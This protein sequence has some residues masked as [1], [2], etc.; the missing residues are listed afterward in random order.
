V[1]SWRY[2]SNVS[3]ADTLAVP[4][5]GNLSI[6]ATS[7]YAGSGAPA[8]YPTQFPWILRLEPGTSNEELVSVS[9]GAGTVAT[10]WVVVRA[11]DGTTAKAH[12]AG[13]AIAHG[14]SAFD[15]TT[16]ANHYALGSGS[17]VHGLPNAAWL[18]SAFTTISEQVTT[19]AQ[20]TVSFSG[21]PGTSAH[22]LLI[23][24]GRLVETSVQS[25]DVTLQFNGDAGAHYSY[26]T[27]LLNNAGGTMTG[28]VS[29]TGFAGTNAP[30]FR[31]LASSGGAAVNAGGGFALIP[32]YTGTAYNKVFYSLS[33]GGNGT[34]SFVD[35][36]TRLGIWNPAAQAAI[37]AITL[38]APTGGF[39]AGCQFSLYGFG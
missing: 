24:T 35:M 4:G 3:V 11:A 19:A 7:L 13:T 10:P 39:D 31:F 17:G 30:L 5:G 20:A 25:D 38:T 34:T 28:P 12:T 9:S 21:I 23:G 33:G 15:L 32:N 14:M 29:G 18:A 36:R 1:V 2:Y 8:G 26:L 27:D 6:G 16:A 22:L 37:T